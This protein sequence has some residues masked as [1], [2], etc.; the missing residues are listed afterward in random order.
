[1][2][3]T[4]LQVL[5][6]MPWRAG[7]RELLA[8]SGLAAQKSFKGHGAIITAISTSSTGTRKRGRLVLISTHSNIYITRFQISERRVCSDAKHCQM[9]VGET[10]RWM[11]QAMSLSK[12]K[13]VKHAGWAVRGA[14]GLEWEGLKQRDEHAERKIIRKPVWPKFCA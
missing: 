8:W 4:S 6:C 12:T 9:C 7:G 1:M 13:L 11:K 10:L 5:G 3:V 2:H 14:W